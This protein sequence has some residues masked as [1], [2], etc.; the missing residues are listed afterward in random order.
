MRE[1]ESVTS[2]LP[3]PYG[4]VVNLHRKRRHVSLC[5]LTLID[6]Q[7][8]SWHV[9]SSLAAKLRDDHVYRF[10]WLG[11]FVKAGSVFNLF[12]FH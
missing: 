9:E 8:G 2:P 10:M 7:R 3:K 5:P 4:L 1:L 6:V 12:A 11:L